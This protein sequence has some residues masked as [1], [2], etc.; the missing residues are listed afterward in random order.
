MLFFVL[1]SAM[2]MQKYLQQTAWSKDFQRK[3]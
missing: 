2:M 1:I 3:K